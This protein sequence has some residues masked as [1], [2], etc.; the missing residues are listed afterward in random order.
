MT[1]NYDIIIIAGAPGSG[2]SSV[3]KSLQEK[4]NCPY[5]EFGWI[6]EFRNKGTE[7]FDYYFGYNPLCYQNL[8]HSFCYR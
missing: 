3:A 6:P 7:T 5:F 1:N 8:K 2:K 4:L